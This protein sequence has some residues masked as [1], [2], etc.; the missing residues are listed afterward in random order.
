[1]NNLFKY[2][3]FLLSLIFTINNGILTGQEN[4][5]ID[6]LK[7]ALSKVSSVDDSIKIVCQIC[8]NSST[9]NPKLTYYYSEVALNLAEKTHDPQLCSE[10]YD[11]GALGFWVTKDTANARLLYKKS[12]TI[13]E[14][15]QLTDRVAWCN[16]N[17]AQLAMNANQ[18]ELA[19]KYVTASQRAF[20][21]AKM[22]RWLINS[23][24]LRIK[25][26]SGDEQRKVYEELVIKLDSL[27]DNSAVEQ[28]LLFYY[29]NI[30]ELYNMLENHSKA[31]EYV[32][33]VFELAEES[34]NIKGILFAYSS[35]GDY[36]RDIQH[37]H[38]LALQ[39][40]Q[41][42]LEMYKSKNINWGIA[43]AQVE[44]GMVYKEMG[45]D[46]LA[47]HYL[48]SAM[49]KARTVEAISTMLRIYIGMG[50][51]YYTQDY[52]N[53]AL[54]LLLEGYKLV[55]CE[56]CYHNYLHD[57]TIKIGS[58]YSSKGDIQDAFNFYKQSVDIANSADDSHLRAISFLKLGDW[59][60]K[61]HNKLKAEQYFLLSMQNS[62]ASRLITQQITSSQKLSQFYY[63]NNQ[64]QK[65]FQYQS[66]MTR[67]K[68]SLRLQNES[69]NLSRIENLFELENL[70]MQKEVDRAHADAKIERQV[71]IRNFF[72]GGFLLVSLLGIYLYVSFRKKRKDNILLTKQKRQ[73]ELMSEKVHEVDEMK[74]QFFTNISHELR[75][76]LS[77]ITGLTE[78]LTNEEFNKKDL[79]E[80]LHTIYRNAS[81]L[82]LLVNQILDIRKLDNGGS[83][84][85]LIKDDMVKYIGGIVSAFKDFAKQK[86]IELVF[87]SEKNSLFTEYDFDKL[88][89][90]L[91]NL[92]SNAIKFCDAKDKVRVTFYSKNDNLDTCILEVDDTG[93][94]I[95]EEHLKYIFE[96]F[97]QANNSNGGSGLGLALVRELVRLLKGKIDVE[98]RIN[99]G[100]RITL[101]LPVKQLEEKSFLDKTH[102]E[103]PEIHKQ[104]PKIKSGVES[105]TNGSSPS[106]FTKLCDEKTLLI[107]EDNRDLQDFITDIV[108]TH[109]KVFNALNG[110]DGIELAIKQIP[111]IIIC[112][113][114]MPGID[115][116]Q[117]CEKLKND[118]CTSHIPIL[119][120]TAKTDQD[121]MLKS[122]KLGADDYIVKPFSAELL[123]TRI[124]N[125]VEQR[126][127][128]IRKFSQKF[129]VEPTE[130]ILP[131][132][133]KTFL[134]KIIKLIEENIAE[135]TLDIDFLASEMNVSRTQLYRK[136]KAL[137]DLSGNQFI[138]LIRL[139]RAA[140][141]LAQNQLNIAEVMQETGFSNYSHFNSCFREQ[142]K[143]SPKE[144]IKTA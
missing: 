73:I 119:M 49:E 3:K 22:E 65:A 15:H 139:K 113:I 134:E 71:L 70:R 76:P 142:F 2:I 114:M 105:N 121:S 44:I 129:Q 7:T 68:D 137:T 17:L 108:K 90:I 86:N 98:S 25:L 13:G 122:F 95:P 46:S 131:D 28:D 132:A 27:I 112:D 35:I 102:V 37:N 92:L 143:K 24:W 10:A 141:L 30:A 31:I 48:N 4:N 60:W 36:L 94:G 107:V 11:A 88:D 29:L 104:I 33:R 21:E 106:S 45:N 101:Q 124:N 100:T 144:F 19:L 96:P 83:A 1:M 52:T 26:L 64:Y 59:Y 93:R 125:L 91:S 23:Y 138:R 18:R 34:N 66:L 38:K 58:I 110:E 87:V 78:Q 6:S 117:L 62:E 81:K 16:Y 111:D 47:L 50:E 14:E 75:T 32:L 41:R 123:K 51:I 43:D 140:Q 57:I 42:T 79:K 116:F 118:P 56:N 135:N 120:L 109:F 97:Y 80:K 130:I 12:L 39:Y 53:K 74:L 72:L 126:K 5:Y 127:K 40:Y 9:S 77:L 128:L 69:D 54:E 63:D 99:I 61:R 89:K 85:I 55:K 133:D 84:L 103:K 67:L 82:H 136:L 8:W 115:G 20:Q